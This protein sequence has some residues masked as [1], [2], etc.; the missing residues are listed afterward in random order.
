[1]VSDESLTLIDFSKARQYITTEGE[2]IRDDGKIYRPGFG[3]TQLYSR[4]TDLQALSQLL[5]GFGANLEKFDE[6]LAQQGEEPDYSRLRS[7]LSH[8]ED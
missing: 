4:K 3:V 2:I 7:A 1:L 6:E 5:K 8:R